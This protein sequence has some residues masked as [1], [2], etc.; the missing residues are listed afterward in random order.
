MNRTI[1]ALLMGFVTTAAVAQQKADSTTM[2]NCGDR[3]F[4]TSKCFDMI[5]SCLGILLSMIMTAQADDE[6]P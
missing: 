2:I 6:Y 3:I 1:I 4:T 5:A